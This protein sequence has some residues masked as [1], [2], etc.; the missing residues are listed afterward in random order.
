MAFRLWESKFTLG[1]YRLLAVPEVIAAVW[2][3]WLR[4]LRPG[5]CPDRAASEAEPSSD[6]SLRCCGGIGT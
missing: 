5:R 2:S 1:R 4:A 3:R 6:N